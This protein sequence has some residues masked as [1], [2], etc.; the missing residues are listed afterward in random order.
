M[1]AGFSLHL[2]LLVLKTGSKT[3][4]KMW[5]EFIPCNPVSLKHINIFMYGFSPFLPFRINLNLL[6]SCFEPPPFFK[7]TLNLSFSHHLISTITPPT[8]YKCI[9]VCVLM[10]QLIQWNK[11]FQ[12]KQL[13][14]G[15]PP[16][17][18]PSSLYLCSRQMG[19][20]RYPFSAPSYPLCLL[21]KRTGT[22]ELY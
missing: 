8:I 5:W 19:I 14:W 12:Q 21:Q 3:F 2:Q 15:A 22:S 17:C 11:L 18:N 1:T 13:L 10:E 20:I 4:T 7:H 6:I 16:P 9:H